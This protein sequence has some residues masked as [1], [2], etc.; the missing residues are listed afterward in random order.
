MCKF[1]FKVKKKEIKIAL[2]FILG[3]VLVYW[4]INYLKGKNVFSSQDIY[5]AKY[6]NVAGLEEANP[7]MLNGYKIGQISTIDFLE[8][9]ILQ[10][11][12]LI[13]EDVSIP[14]NSIARIESSDLLGSKAVV[15]HFG[16]AKEM[17]KSGDYLVGDIERDLKEEVSMQILPLKNKAEDLISSFDSVLIILQSI[18][19]EDVR[20]NLARSFQSIENT[21]KSIERTS[22]NLDTLMSSQRYRLAN[23][24]ANVESITSNLKENN[25][26]LNNILSNMSSVSDSLAA[27]PI[28]TIINNANASLE[29]FDM[30]MTKIKNG[31]G[32]IGMLINNDLLYNNLNKSAKDLDLLIEDLR[33]NPQRY[34]HFSIFGRNAKRN[35]YTPRSEN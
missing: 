33:L 21:V 19:N 22:Y 20:E 29:K 15:I 10:V 3:F 1:Q 8:D 2:I 24:F 7:V 18:F 16:D 30:V 12:L 35:A 14:K 31:E 23:I 26:K 27:A 6:N 17:M 28:K 9:G 4:G 34:M 25:E 11:G 32:S 13:T 5:Y